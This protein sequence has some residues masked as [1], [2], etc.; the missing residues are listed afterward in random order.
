VKLKPRN[1][2]ETYPDKKFRCVSITNLGLF[3]VVPEL[4]P[5]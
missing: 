1:S 2:Y 4:T 3:E 5:I